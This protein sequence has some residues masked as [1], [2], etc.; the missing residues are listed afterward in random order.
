[1]NPRVLFVI[2]AMC[3]FQFKSDVKVMPRYLADVTLS[4][5]RGLVLCYKADIGIGWDFYFG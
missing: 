5:P 3:L 1:M 4:R 2:V